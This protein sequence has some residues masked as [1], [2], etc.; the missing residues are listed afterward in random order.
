M[1]DIGRLGELYFVNTVR[2]PQCKNAGK[3][4]LSVD[5]RYAMMCADVQEWHEAGAMRSSEEAPPEQIVQKRGQVVNCQ[6]FLDVFGNQ[7]HQ[8][9]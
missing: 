7:T 1:E 6:Q 8:T 2:E 9:S 4:A 5:V 3:C